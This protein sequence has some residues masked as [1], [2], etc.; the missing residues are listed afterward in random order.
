M[1]TVMLFC[2]GLADE[3]VADLGGRT[4]F[5]L[6]KTPNLDRLAKEGS[7]GS[8]S[9]VPGTL[10]VSP[11][12]ACFSILGYD[13]QE[14][15]TGLAPLDALALGVPQDDRAVA[16]R[17][18]LVTVLDDTLQD[19]TAGH[20]SSK[21]AQPLLA[22]LGRLI[23]TDRMKLCAGEGYK[24]ILVVNDDA[25]GDDL[26]DLETTAPSR[27]V[28]QSYVKGLPKGRSE[29]VISSLMKKSKEILDDQEINRVRIDLK[30]NPANMLWLWGQGRKP[31]LPPF[32]ERH[33]VS[34]AT[35]SK[36]D[37]V[38]GIGAAAG[39][40]HADDVRSALKDHDFVFVY[41]APPAPSAELKARVKRIEDFDQEVGEALRALEGFENARVCAGT[42]AVFA[43]TQ[44]R[45]SS[46]APTP[47][48]VWG[49]GVP[50]SGAAGFSE[51]TA[52]LSRVV[53]SEG[54]TLINHLTVKGKFAP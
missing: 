48:A 23:S 7:M 15:Y 53:L 50:A 14:Y 2:H 54:R 29:S 21:E 42:D 13:P 1:K 31:K 44:D 35:V 49:A 5:E 47:F 24:N 46:H 33:G 37:F 20:I 18:D 8:A 51:K 40:D 39:F 41:S 4:P 26:D 16:F 43:A 28:G 34:G 25:L 22:E 30:E 10:A 12:A 17:A 9:F 19:A 52:A 3:P 32:R 11:D 38:K 6:A 27:L 45:P 36:E